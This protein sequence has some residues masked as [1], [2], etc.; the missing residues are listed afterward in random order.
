MLDIFSK[1]SQVIGL[2]ISSTSVK[3]LEVSRGKL[4]MQVESYAVEPL[5][6]NSV[7]EKTIQDPEAV[8]EAVRRVVKKSG[9][10]SN[11]AAVAVSGSA[12]ITKVITAPAGLRD[13]ELETQV[14]LAADQHIPYAL[15]EVNIDFQV[16]GPSADDS[17]QVDVLLAATKSENIDDREL[18][19]K[20]AGLKPAIVDVEPYTIE[21]TM[22]LII[23]EDEERAKTTIAVIDV[24][25]TMTSLNVIQDRQLIYTREQPFGGK[26]LTEEIM[27]RYG[28]SYQDAGRAKRVGGLPEDYIPEVLEPF[29]QSIAQHINRYLQFYYSSSQDLE[30]DEILLAGGSSSIEGI[31]EYIS[32]HIGTPT[33][34]VNP[35]ERI[36]CREGIDRDR[37]IQDGPA[38]MIACGLALRGTE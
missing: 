20:I 33:S 1:R 25:A 36:D 21:H 4:G 5:P 7:N 30:V 11:R 15:N 17:K 8:G 27:R 31:D 29:K 24:G 16:L 38:M 12:V 10:K 2:D 37:L 9:T 32:D 35:F 34:I 26:L 19:L 3:L 14:M 6:V 13:T 18:V 23:G 28:L 22:D